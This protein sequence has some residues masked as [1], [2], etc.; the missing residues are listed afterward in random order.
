MQT[1]TESTDTPRVEDEY[2]PGLDEDEDRKMF[3]RYRARCEGSAVLYCL[4]LILTGLAATG[5]CAYYGQWLAIVLIFLAVPMMPWPFAKNILAML[6]F[7]QI[8]KLLPFT[9]CPLFRVAAC[10]LLWA[11]G[12][13]IPAVLIG[14]NAV[15]IVLR[16]LVGRRNARAVGMLV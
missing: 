6:P 10:V 4:P 12:Y 7:L 3:Y 13:W 11:N 5:F 9:F 1:V 16:E 14:L 8:L 2:Q 15:M